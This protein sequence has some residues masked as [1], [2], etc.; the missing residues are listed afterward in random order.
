MQHSVQS[1]SNTECRMKSLLLAVLSSIALLLSN[2]APRPVHHA[3]RFV[4]GEDCPHYWD[5]SSGIT[6]GLDTLPIAGPSTNIPEYN[7]CQRMIVPLSTGALAYAD[8]Q[9]VWVRYGIENYFATLPAVGS[10]AGTSFGPLIGPTTPRTRL[11]TVGV[12][13]GM[14]NYNALGVKEGFNCIVLRWE[15]GAF[16][17]A[18]SRAWMVP[19]TFPDV[20]DTPLNLPAG[21]ATELAVAAIPPRVEAGVA[22]LV[23]QVA[24]WDW[25]DRD[26]LQYVS[27]WCPAGWCEFHGPKFQ[28][29]ARYSATGTL[30]ARSAIRVKGWY[31]EQYLMN[32]YDAATTPRPEDGLLRGTVFP[33]PGLDGRKVSAYTSTWLKVATVSLAKASVRYE[34]KYRYERD[35]APPDGK[36]NVV[37]MCFESQAS[38]YAG[39]PGCSG[40]IPNRCTFDSVNIGY[41][42]ARIV[43]RSGRTKALCVWYHPTAGNLQPPGTVRWRWTL[44]D[45][46]IWVACPTGCC[47]VDGIG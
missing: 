28:T 8:V 29:S 13:W 46:T 47:E 27:L 23:P 26:T 6:H 16:N 10:T 43:S 17:A 45:E 20:C 40:E 3:P 21:R 9:A 7:D 24:R 12:V 18:T 15:G 32:P 44:K 38:T 2:V 39:T 33:A 30:K 4:N 1:T 19:V 22:D 25:D 41:W 34:R 14:G 31:D 35:P 36:D 42:Y 11:G 5:G 37:Y